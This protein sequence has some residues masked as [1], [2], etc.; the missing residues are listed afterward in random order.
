MTGHILTFFQLE[1]SQINVKTAPY[2]IGP[3]ETGQLQFGFSLCER[4]QKDFSGID[5]DMH[6][7][8][9]CIDVYF[10]MN[11]DVSCGRVAFVFYFGF[12]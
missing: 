6:T 12:S 11:G 4:T 8:G 7:S 10:S 3:E 9:P 1:V 2:K 5:I